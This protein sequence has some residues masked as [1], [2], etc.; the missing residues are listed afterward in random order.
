MS[1]A[2]FVLAIFTFQSWPSNS[3]APVKMATITSE[4]RGR[5]NWTKVST[6][7]L[8]ST[9]RKANQAP[10]RANKTMRSGLQFL[11]CAA[12]C[13]LGLWAHFCV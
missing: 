10:S 3:I 1:I 7:T 6:D 13:E 8:V 9:E 4:A 2:L 11:C 12:L 5:H